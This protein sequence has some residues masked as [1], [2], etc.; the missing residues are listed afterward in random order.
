MGF[1]LIYGVTRILNLAH[2]AFYMLTGYVILSLLSRTNINPFLATIASLIILSVFGIVMY[3]L[4]ILPVI[5]SETSVIMTTIALYL[6]CERIIVSTMGDRPKFIPS[7]LSGV[8]PVFGVPVVNQRWLSL[9]LAVA[10]ISILW[11]LLK[12]TKVGKAVRA[13]AID[14]EAAALMGINVERIFT[15][16]MAISAAL[17]AL[18][19]AMVIPITTLTP[20]VGLLP[21][22][23]AFII[24]VFGGLGS[25]GGSISAAFII[26]Y[27]EVTVGLA[28]ASWLKDVVPLIMVLIMLFIRPSGL[29]GKPVK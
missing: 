22:T 2:G 15:L 8:T 25:V 11:I 12:R 16:T 1:T 3:K 27:A 9:L 20:A 28:V 13:V 5:H 21:L 19:G 10:A 4:L 26:S 14:R 7:L 18:A 23:K 17:A 29:F 24:V 6:F